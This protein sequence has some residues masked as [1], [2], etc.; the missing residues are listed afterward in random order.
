[1]ESPTTG[2]STQAVVLPVLSSI[3]VV[4]SIPPIILHWKNRNFPATALI[5]WFLISNT[6]NIINALIWPT[7]DVDSWWDGQGLC[8]V[9]TKVMIASYVAVPGTLVCIFR[10]LAS[11]LDTRRAMLVPSTSQRWRNRL[12]DISFCVVIPV[13]AMITHIV[14]QRSRYLIFSISG[15]VNNF[16]QSWVSLVLAFIWPPIICLLAAFYCGITLYRLHK[17][18]SQFGDILNS[19]NSHLNKSRFLRLFFLA[20]IMLCTILPIQAYVVYRNLMYNLPWHPYSWSR[21]HG[22]HSPWSTILKI[23]TQGQVFFDRWIPI[24]AAYVLFIFFG[25]CKDALRLYQSALCP[26]GLGKC[27]SGLR[28]LS[29]GTSASITEGFTASRAKLLSFR[30]QSSGT[31]TT[32]DSTT[33]GTITSSH[34]DIEKGAAS[35]QES[36]STTRSRWVSFP[37]CLLSRTFLSVRE[38]AT[39]GPT[40]SVPATT[41]STNAWAG[42]SQSRGSSDFTH[43]PVG[44][45]SI[46][47]KQVISQESELQV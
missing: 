10:S 42:T 3:A 24:A 36:F 11:V 5:C 40:F 38:T 4:V 19:A 20:C 17:Y 23:P 25:C 13:I 34:E 9:E 35:R 33:S 28:T 46:R 16:D 47:V 44:P 27:L 26:L 1:M 7:D 18:R 22:P 2:R 14:Y 29:Q 41:V 15:C 43:A 21:L 45:D 37:W 12:M 6:F 32:T 8:D 39:S 30:K 31:G